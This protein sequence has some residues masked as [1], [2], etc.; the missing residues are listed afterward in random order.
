MYKTYDSSLKR[1]YANTYS[2]IKMELVFCNI[3]GCVLLIVTFTFFPNLYNSRLGSSQ[4]VAQQNLISTRHQIFAPQQYC[5]DRME[6]IQA[7]QAGKE[8]IELVEKGEEP[9]M[10]VSSDKMKVKE[11]GQTERA[12]NNVR[13]PTKVKLK[14]RPHITGT[15]QKPGVFPHRYSGTTLRPEKALW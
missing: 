10:V 2:V 4:P 7:G 13:S 11:E 15:K 6:C 12:R 14:R 9:V 1:V 3:H 5:L 8:S